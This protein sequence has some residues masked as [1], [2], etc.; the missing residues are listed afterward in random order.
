VSTSGL[1]GWQSRTGPIVESTDPGKARVTFSALGE[2]V[3]TLTVTD[4]DGLIDADTVA[5]SVVEPPIDGEDE[6]SP[7]PGY[8]AGA[9]GQGA[10]LKAQLSQIMA[11]GHVPQTYGAYK[12]TAARY[13]ADPNDPGRILLVYNRASVPGAWDGGATWNRE[14]IWP[15]S[16]QPGNANE[17]TTGNLGDPYSLR[18]CDPGINS[19]RG[20]KPYGSFATIGGHRSLG[21][22]YFP[23]DFDKGDVA[24]ALFYSATRYMSDLSLVNGDPSG[25]SMGDLASLLRWHYTDAPDTFERRRGHLIFLDQH[26][27]NAY[28]DHPEF[29]WSIFGD[30]ANDSTL[31]LSEDRPADGA[32]AV[33]VELGPIIVGGPLPSPSAVTLHKSGSDPT[34]FAVTTSGDATS[35]VTGR[36]NA[37]DYGSQQRSITVGLVAATAAAGV[38]SGT[39]TI[40][41]LDISSEGAGEGS[42]DGNDVIELSL[43]IY[44]HAEASFSAGADDDTL[45]IDLGTAAVNS[46]VRMA[47]FDVFNLPA[48][49]GLTANLDLL[50]V[51]STGDDDVLTTD[52][53]AVFGLPAGAG[54]TFQVAFDPANLAPGVYTAVY[55]INVA[56]E[57]LP[58]G[59]VGNPLTLTVTATVAASLPYDADG[60][61]DV[62]AADWAIFADCL[63]GPAAGY[64]TPSCDALDG[65]FDGD[66][67]LLDAAGFQ[68]AAAAG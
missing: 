2:Y 23:G 32:S 55:T 25:Y 39:V 63:L 68:A 51:N 62:D 37:F 38:V 59:V 4:A 27:R 49:S 33:A 52:A 40:D 28:I 10:A 34:Y 41:N 22:F 43:P 14:H 12:H 56:D 9:V 30:G 21:T 64:A 67:D 24:R 36:F 6:Y 5:I 8:Y 60:D 42:A 47:S 45:L 57:D 61:G 17:S 26:N 31:H 44:D 7:P 1:A 50:G 11:A 66:V 48:E 53:E 16:L 15:Q 54:V 29:V 20:N 35:S 65:D 46:G 3:L 18:P 58:G 13:D 19:T